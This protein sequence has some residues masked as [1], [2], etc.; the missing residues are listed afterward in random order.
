MWVGV[1]VCRSWGNVSP[2]SLPSMRSCEDY[3]FLFAVGSGGP[4][5]V[6]LVF[7]VAFHCVGIESMVFCIGFLDRIGVILV[8]VVEIL[9]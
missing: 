2:R 6:F 5:S 8:Y 7:T 9:G 4:A 3:C 1:K